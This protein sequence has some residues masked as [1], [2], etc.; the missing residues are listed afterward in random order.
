MV[1]GVNNQFDDHKHGALKSAHELFDHLS[2]YLADVEAAA[3]VVGEDNL[4]EEI[5]MSYASA[6]VLKDEVACL[7]RKISLALKPTIM[8]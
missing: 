5:C 3:K 1:A 6:I 2:C 4:Q 8:G 7:R